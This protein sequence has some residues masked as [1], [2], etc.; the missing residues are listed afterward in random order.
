MTLA[1]GRHYVGSLARGVLTQPCL[2]G[3]VTAI[4]DVTHLV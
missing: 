4:H 1:A 3:A 2:V